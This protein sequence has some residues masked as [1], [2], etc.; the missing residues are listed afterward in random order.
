MKRAS[1][2]LP[3]FILLFY[4]AA[5]AGIPEIYLATSNLK[6]SPLNWSSVKLFSSP[7][8]YFRSRQIGDWSDMNTW[9]SSPDNVSWSNATLV[10]AVAARAISI[11][12]A[13]TVTVSTNQS[14]NQVVIETGGIL[15]HTGGMLTINDETGDDVIVRIGAVF[16]LADN[17]NG[18][19]F[20][21][22]T[23]SAYIST[24]GTLRLSATGLTSAGLGIHAS[25]YIYSNA[26]I[27]EY[28]LNFAFSTAG[29]TY[30]PNANAFTVP[31]FRITNNVADV[32]ANTPTVFNGL[33]EANGNITFQ[34]NGTKTFR[35]GIIGTGNVTGETA[36]GKFMINGS[37]ATLGGVGTLTVP[38]TNGM[39]IGNGTGTN[40]SLVSNKTITNNF[41]LL[42]NTYLSLNDNNLTLNG[43]IS[44]GSTNAHLVTGGLGK[45]VINNIGV[46]P[47]TFPVSG[48]F[49]TY[50]PIVIANG[51]GLNYGVRVKTGINPPIGI[52]L[53]AVNRTWFITPY[54]GNPGNVHVNFFYVAGH[55]NAG[56]NYTANLE[57]GHYTSAWNVVQAGL[58]P[59]GTYQVATSFN[60]LANNMEAPLVLANIGAILAS[61]KSVVVNYFNGAN[62]KNNHLLNWK[63]N[64]NS[65]P[66]VTMVME[67]S[68]DGWNYVPVFSEHA[69]AL[70]CLQPF[71]F[72]DQQPAAGINYYRLKIIDAGGKNSYS[73]V[74]TLSHAVKNIDMQITPNPVV[75][76]WFNLKICTVKDELFEILISDMQGRAVQ[77]NIVGLTAGINTIPVYITNL[78]AGTYQLI[79]K[80]GE[81]GLKILR[82]VVQ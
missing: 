26:S 30:F 67:R 40:V 38:F 11:R 47:V 54:G 57:L 1:F 62:Q 55:A 60:T 73:T 76:G 80:P 52:S 58:V 50:N 70:R 49:A 82:F 48:N 13:H 56:F 18:P 51:G 14:M 28:T 59:T 75:T 4:Y 31:I 12:N 17:N 81:G 69:T 27:L 2:L 3:F 29:V 20:S 39:E 37:S 41:T 77:K 32:G 23:A 45:L 71:T 15:V 53:Q 25:N 63:L 74:I 33:F 10:P 46:T 66:A 7:D 42:S 61:A 36:C 44:G 22:M 72:T 6:T 79:A 65:T 24:G 78:A 16:T 35:N 5:T 9:E 21:P 19:L 43:A 64:C 68:T 8:D 34:N